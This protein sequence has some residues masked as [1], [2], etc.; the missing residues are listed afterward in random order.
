MRSRHEATSCSDVMA[1]SRMRRAA[2]TAES[3]WR[4]SIATEGSCSTKRGALRQAQVKGES[5]HPL[6]LPKGEGKKSHTEIFF[7]P[8]PPF[9]ERTEV[10]VALFPVQKFR[11]P[12]RHARPDVHEH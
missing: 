1:P 7:L 5:P 2:S 3:R 6:P 9:G 11:Q 12:Q 4:F 8:P 10:G